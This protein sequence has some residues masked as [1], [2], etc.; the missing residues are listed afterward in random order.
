MPKAGFIVCPDLSIQTQDEISPLKRAT[1]ARC[2]GRVCGFDE[3][4]P[5][6]GKY[7]PQKE[8]PMKPIRIPRPSL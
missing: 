8:D 2:Y 5:D 6:L 3:L 7:L 1:Q 4:A